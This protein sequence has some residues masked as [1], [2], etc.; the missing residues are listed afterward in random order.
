MNNGDMLILKRSDLPKVVSL[1]GDHGEQEFYTIAP[2]S[3]KFGASL[4][5]ITGL[6]RDALLQK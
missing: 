4:Q 1:V 2:A 5:K 6:L 3:R